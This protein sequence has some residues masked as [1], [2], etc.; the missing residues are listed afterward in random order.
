MNAWNNGCRKPGQVYDYEA[1]RP[2]LAALNLFPTDSARLLHSSRVPG[3]YINCGTS[4]IKQPYIYALLVGCRCFF[5]F[6]FGIGELLR[7]LS[8]GMLKLVKNG[9]SSELFFTVPVWAM[10]S[11][12]TQLI[13][14]NVG[15]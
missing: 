12:T 1:I 3:Y 5:V 11:N 2:A 8:V 13:L 15:L 4:K 14:I 6:V 10:H 7:Q 9:L